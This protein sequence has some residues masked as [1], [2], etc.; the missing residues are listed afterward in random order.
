MHKILKLLTVL[1]VVVILI[2]LSLI[3]Y[4]AATNYNPEDIEN[5][6]IYNDANKIM[7]VSKEFTVTTYNI[8]YA[9][10]DKSK[11]FFMD[12]GK[13]SKSTSLEKTRE[14]L[15]SVLKFI[16]E[17]NSDFYSLQEIDVK[18]TRSFDI[19]QAKLIADRYD[20]YASAFAYNYK[21]KLV[22]VPFNDPMGYVNS[23]IM[24]LS[25]FKSSSN[26]RYTLPGKESFP[27]IY[28]MLDR[29]I[30][31][32]VT[33]LSNGKELLFINLHLSAFDKGGAIRAQQT[34]FLIDYIK[35]RKNENNY[36]ILSGDW[37]HLL[38]KSFLENFD[39]E[40]PD[41]VAL[42]PEELS[43]LAFT[44]VADENVNTIRATST[45]YVKGTSFETVIDGFLI[46]DDIEVLEVTGHDLGFEYTDHNPVSVKLKFKE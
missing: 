24:T 23:G 43:K 14:N 44:L 2:L 13:S 1:I 38:S 11:D 36:I 28:F 33:P 5:A 37:N 12:G 10:L 3:A 26:T 9:G 8:G 16:D 46:S 40:L 6:I 4:A 34:K 39:G 42:L 30:M 29:C 18:S 22:P 21:V 7:D 15:N 45:P 19:D 41:W 17:T 35:E 27:R 31:E 25:K 32:T 20:E